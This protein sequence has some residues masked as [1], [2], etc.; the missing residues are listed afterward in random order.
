MESVRFFRNFQVWQ[1][2]IFKEEFVFADGTKNYCCKNV[3]SQIYHFLCAKANFFSSQSFWKWSIFGEMLKNFA[4]VI[5][6]EVTF[7]S[8]LLFFLDLLGVWF[9]DWIYLAYLLSKQIT[10]WLVKNLGDRRTSVLVSFSVRTLMG[11]C[12]NFNCSFFH[13]F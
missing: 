9:C 8:I 10:V 5:F 7:S 13:I 4:V 2:Y 11:A 6:M 12:S 3:L 1:K